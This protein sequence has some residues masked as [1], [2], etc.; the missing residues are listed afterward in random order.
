[1]KNDKKISIKLINRPE[2]LEKIKINRNFLNNAL[3][4]DIIKN[5]I[6]IRT[7]EEGDFFH[8]K[9]RGITKSIKK[10]FNEAKVPQ[11]ER[12]TKVILARGKEAFWIE[13]FG[14]GEKAKVTEKTNQIIIINIEENFNVK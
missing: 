3:D 13:G 4:Y 10:L 6:K 8:I 14:V 2:Y 7:R 11:E 1:M 5:G 9:N 12:N